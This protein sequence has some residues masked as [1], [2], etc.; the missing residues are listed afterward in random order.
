MAQ[1]R[2]AQA[3]AQLRNRDAPV[4]CNCAIAMIF[5]GDATGFSYSSELM[6]D[7]TASRLMRAYNKARWAVMSSR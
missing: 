3:F 7:S 1:L 2:V 4:L 5:E 6:A